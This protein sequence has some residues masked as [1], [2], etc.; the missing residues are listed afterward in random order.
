[1]KTHF[2]R[3][4]AIAL[5]TLAPFFPSS[6]EVGI[7]A[8]EM[9]SLPMVSAVQQAQKISVPLRES[10]GTFSVSVEI[11]GRVTVDM[12]IDSGAADVAVSEEV[13]QSLGA[14]AV[15][16]GEREYRI[17]NGSFVR[18]SLITIRTLKVGELVLNDV[19]ASVGPGPLLL[20]QTFLMRLGSWSIDNTTHE[21]VL[22]ALPVPVTLPRQENPTAPHAPSNG[23]WMIQVGTFPAEEGARQRLSSVQSQASRYLAIADAYTERVTEGNSILYR[24]RFAGLGKEQAEAA[25]KYLRRNN[26]DCMTV[27]N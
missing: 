16:V 11:N 27:R 21:L 4:A 14:D 1:M 10:G 12:L 24:A 20:G 23:G 22:A 15:K 26:I 18:R 8:P 19:R 13:F 3:T 25:C 6:A 17:A 9:Q 5:L 7:A 2:P